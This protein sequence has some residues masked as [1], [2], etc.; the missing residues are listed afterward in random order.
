MATAKGPRDR[1]PDPG[2]PSTWR[3]TGIAPS[4]SA[5][6][7]TSLARCTVPN[8]EPHHALSPFRPLS[9]ALPCLEQIRPRGRL[10][11][12][13]LCETHPAITTGDMAWYLPICT[14]LILSNCRSPVST[15]VYRFT[16]FQTC[17]LQAI[18][19]ART[20]HVQC[21]REHRVKGESSRLSH[22]TRVLPMQQ[23][24]VIPY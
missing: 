8:L 1:P 9:L 7:P 12:S 3:T 5:A 19:T 2:P 20:C 23:S 24:N 18:S 14:N 11:L 22:V 13:E 21:G 17:L 16:S 4:C 15:A 6:S 10:P